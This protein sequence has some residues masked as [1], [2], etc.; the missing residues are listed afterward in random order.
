[1]EE[2]AELNVHRRYNQPSGDSS[3]FTQAELS[4]TIPKKE[5]AEGK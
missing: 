4:L 3:R 1:M 5:D 2:R